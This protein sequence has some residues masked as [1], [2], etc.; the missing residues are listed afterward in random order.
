MAHDVFDFNDRIVNQDPDHQRQRQQ[1]HAVESKA[2][3]VHRHESGND[4]QR[5][6]SSSHQRC[7]PVAQ[8]EP[9]HQHCQ[10][11]PL[12]QQRH[13][14]IVVFLDCVDVIESFFDLDVRRFLVQRGDRFFYSLGYNDFASALASCDFK[15]DHR[16]AVEQGNRRAFTYAISY[17]GDLVQA[18]NVTVRQSHLQRSDL[19]HIA[20]GADGAHRLPGAADIG[21]AARRLLLHTL[22]LARDLRRRYVQG[23]HAFRVEFNQHLTVDTTDPGYLPHTLNRQQGFGNVIINKPGQCLFI[24]LIGFYGVGDDRLA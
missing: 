9:D 4:R 20:D 2:K 3:V 18:N 15:S 24:Q 6:S 5:Q 16:F 19:S 17:L 22:Q 8:E 14:T 7:A 1:S 21:F 12:I 11:R 10:D 13:G 23:R